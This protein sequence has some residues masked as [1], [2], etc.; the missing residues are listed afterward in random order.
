MVTKRL[1]TRP[2]L[3][4]R[5]RFVVL[6]AGLPNFRRNLATGQPERVLREKPNQH[7]E[8]LGAHPNVF[9]AH[10]LPADQADIA[11]FD[12]LVETGL[13][14]EKA[15]SCLHRFH[16]VLNNLHCNYC[17]DPEDQALFGYIALQ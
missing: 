15:G 2:A 13:I 11:S 7:F 3:R 1:Q 16:F 17:S 12:Q 6:R 10:G 4:S 5:L 8:L 14:Y 9:V